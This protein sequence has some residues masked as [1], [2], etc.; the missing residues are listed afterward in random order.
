[1]AVVTA[2]MNAMTRKGACLAT[3]MVAL[4]EDRAVVT[5]VEMAVEIVRIVEMAA[6]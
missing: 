6:G 1:M 3:M 5:A 2:E 4:K